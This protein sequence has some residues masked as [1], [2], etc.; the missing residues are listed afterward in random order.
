MRLTWEADG[1]LTDE[2]SDE[3]LLLDGGADAALEVALVE[4]DNLLRCEN[5][6]GVFLTK[7]SVQQVVCM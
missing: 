4:H 7:L 1:T 6:L 2:A 5:N 3:L